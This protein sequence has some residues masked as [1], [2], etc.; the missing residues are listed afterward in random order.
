MITPELVTALLGVGG[1][2]Y[3]I[4]K[5]I[6]GWKAWKSGKALREKVENR[7]LLQ[8][9]ISAEA[10]ADAEAAFRRQFQEYAGILRVMLVNMGFPAKDLPPEPVRKETAH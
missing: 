2:G 3:I 9:L 4:P 10:R 7:S 5:S 8:K 1:L 6:D